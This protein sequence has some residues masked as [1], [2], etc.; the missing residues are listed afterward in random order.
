M[1]VAM[2]T[3]IDPSTIPG[4]YSF[5]ALKQFIA[6]R[7]P[8]APVFQRRLVEVPFRF[9]HPVWI[10]DPDFDIDYHVRLAAVPGPGGLRELAS[11]AGDITGRP[12]DRA[13]PLWEMWI[14]E[15]LSDGRIGFIAKMHHST[16]DGV[17]GAE[18]LSVLF[19]LEPDPP[20]RP[21]PD[22]GMVDSH[23]PSSL[24]LITQAAVA[25]AVRP[26]EMVKDIFTTGQHIL[27]VRQ[28]RQQSESRP[29]LGKAALP[30]SAPRTSFN[31]S[32]T[33]RRS[34]ALSAIGLDDVKR[35]KDAR[36]TTVNDVVLAVCTGAL[37][38][39]LTDGD[40][41]PDKPLVAVVPVSVRPSNPDMAGSN[42]VSSMFVQLPAQL[43]DPLERLEA[44][45][46]GTKGAKEEHNALGAET[47]L[48]WTEHA[49]PNVFAAGARFYSRMK[50]AERHRPI[51]NLVISNVPGPDFPLYFGG[52]EL[53]AGFPL[54]PVMDGMG[55]NVT[56]MSYRGVLYWGIMACPETIPKVWNLAAD[57]PLALDELLDAAG[58]GP[59]TY[60]STD[61]ADAVRA[62]G[63]DLPDVSTRAATSD[64]QVAK[65]AP[66]KKKA[67]A[68]KKATA[69]KVAARKAA[70]AK[71]TAAKEPASVQADPP[72]DRAATDP[73]APE[74][75]PDP[76]GAEPGSANGGQA[77][78]APSWP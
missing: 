67:T 29:G 76:S 12:L 23:V 74:P 28:V 17:S 44:I 61:A 11:I 32:L 60:R 7:I 39:F 70:P 22:P 73:W 25:R 40:E 63:I 52:A 31:G 1:H 16:V 14:I 55:V 41:L 34:V 33:R 62:A 9:G 50:L 66:A 20:E 21:A 2:T 71:E 36:G 65:T 8:H 48:N 26:F 59:A 51:A 30:L 13:R 75:E 15:G 68:Q 49:T 35:L 43:E 37:R 56:I 38:R 72:S 3:I 42:K 47:L 77:P 58:L 24:E 78:T 18:L 5:E 45:H 6:K 53:Q 27:H 46:E 10:D 69:K 64:R 4:G 54:G 19:D 57:I